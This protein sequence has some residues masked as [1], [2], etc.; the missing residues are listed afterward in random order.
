MTISKAKFN[1][2]ISSYKIRRKSRNE[3]L[4]FLAFIIMYKISRFMAIGTESTAFANA[5]LVI[6]IE[7]YLGIFYEVSIQQF[8]LEHQGII[9]ALNQI[10]MRLHIPSSILFF[11]WLFRTDQKNYYYARN[12]FVIA[13]IITL[14]FYV[15]FPTAPPRMLR[16]YGFVDTLLTQ[17]HINL[18]QGILSKL[19]NQYAAVPSMHFG[20]AL[21]ICIFTFSLSKIQWLKWSILLYP[22][23][24]LM[25]IVITG[26]HFF[27]DAILGGIVVL[28]PF[29]IFKA[30]ELFF[31]TE[32][33]FSTIFRSKSRMP[34]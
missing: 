15:G 23:F 18:Y 16:E 9:K 22:V 3:L 20:M 32:G 24:V 19:F 13:N 5:Y 28:V 7:K 17:S 4:F 25:V 26:N 12:V 21:L 29:P 30:Y 27:I 8:F 31:T 1:S 2:I 14:F 33:K 34:Y 10:Y 11:V 6:D